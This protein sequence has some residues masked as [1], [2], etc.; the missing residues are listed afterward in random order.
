[1][2]NLTPNDHMWHARNPFKSRQCTI[3]QSIRNGDQIDRIEVRISSPPTVSSRFGLPRLLFV[4]KLEK[5][6]D[7]QKMLLK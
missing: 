4:T 7:W 1:M 6:V 3:T 2:L 5:M